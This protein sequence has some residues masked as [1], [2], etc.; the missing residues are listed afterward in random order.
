MFGAEDNGK[1]LKNTSKKGGILK[2]GVCLVLEVNRGCH[3]TCLF[4]EKT[5][6]GISSV[7]AVLDNS[8]FLQQEIYIFKKEVYQN[9]RYHIHQRDQIMVR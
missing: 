2:A 1:N 8:Q 5:T 7:W 9:H 3:V 4:D 6:S